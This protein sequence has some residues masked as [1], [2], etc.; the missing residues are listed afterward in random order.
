MTCKTCKDCEY[1]DDLLCDLLGILVEDDDLACI[2]YK[3]KNCD[4]FQDNDTD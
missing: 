3:N 2:K 4:N 1:N